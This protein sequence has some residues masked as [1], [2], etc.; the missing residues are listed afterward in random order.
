MN[1]PQTHCTRSVARVSR[2]SDETLRHT[3]ARCVAALGYIPKVAEF[4][5]WRRQ[6]LRLARAR[7]DGA[8]ELPSSSAYRRRWQGWESALRALAYP[9]PAIQAR[10]ERL[11]A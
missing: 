8:L 7:G 11:S 5:G 9:E 10:L 6:E 4:D 1:I 3:L 2:Y